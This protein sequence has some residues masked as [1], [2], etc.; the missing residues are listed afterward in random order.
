[1]EDE[2]PIASGESLDLFFK[3]KIS[4]CIFP[5]ATVN[6]TLKAYVHIAAVVCLQESGKGRQISNFHMIILLLLFFF[7][8]GQP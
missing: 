8:L 7:L 5:L 4:V 2:I 3:E 1:M 6:D